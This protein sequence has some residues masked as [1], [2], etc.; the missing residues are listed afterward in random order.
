MR[1]ARPG[2]RTRRRDCARRADR[3][4]EVASRR[5]P[6]LGCAVEATQP[7]EIIRLREG[8]AA[9]EGNARAFAPTLA[10][11]LSISHTTLQNQMFTSDLL[12]NLFASKNNGI[13][14]RIK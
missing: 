14:S 1:S 4:T 11:L 9:T 5:G 6:H 13:P 2:I 3:R 12:F 8:A 7:G 10:E